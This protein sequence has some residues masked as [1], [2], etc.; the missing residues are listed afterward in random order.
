MFFCLFAPE[1]RRRGHL[2]RK[3]N[4]KTCEPPFLVM[5][6]QVDLC[7]AGSSTAVLSVLFS[8]GKCM[9]FFPFKKKKENE[10]S[11]PHLIRGNGEWRAT[12]L[13]AQFQEK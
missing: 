10:G 8:L 12:N 5:S 11:F 3:E 7:E 1:V 4:T 2:P 13:N 6:G 9:S